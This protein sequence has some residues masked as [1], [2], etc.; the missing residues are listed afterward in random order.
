MHELTTEQEQQL[1]EDLTALDWT[2]DLDTR[3]TQ[4]ISERLDCS[5][6]DA[7][8]ILQRL[9]AAKITAVSESG[10]TPAASRALDSYGWKWIVMRTH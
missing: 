8:L 2:R 4:V 6:E 9:R 5:L 10:G 1:L 3:S 7:S